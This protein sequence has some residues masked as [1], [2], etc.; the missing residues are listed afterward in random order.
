MIAE[1]EAANIVKPLDDIN[2]AFQK[3]ITYLRNMGLSV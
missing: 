3:S 1:V 2:N